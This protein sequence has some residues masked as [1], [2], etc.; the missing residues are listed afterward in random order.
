MLVVMLVLS[1]LDQTIVATALP[2]IVRELGRED[3]AS[4]VFSSYLLSATV[5]VP[6]YGRLADIYGSKPI[7][8]TAITL[9]LA[10]S[11][12]SGVSSSMLGLIWAR[13]LQGAGGGGLLT[14]AMT[15]VAVL[16]EPSARSRLQGMLGAAYGLSVMVGPLLGGSLVEH[17]SW[18][19]AF[20]L[21][22]PI[23][24]VALPVLI[25]KFPHHKPTDGGAMDY[26]GAVLL[27]GA[28]VSLLLSTRTSIT[29]AGMSPLQFAGLAAVL[30]A[31][32][33]VVQLR[34][35]SPLFPLRLFAQ[36]GF[37]AVTILSV[38]TG[39]T[40]FAVV[41]FMP[42]YFQSARGVT[43][44]SSGL[45]TL[46]LMA[47]VTFASIAAGRL[48]A[49][50][51]HVR[52]T[53]LLAGAVTVLG[54]TVLGWL[55][56]DPAVPLGWVSACLVPVGA[57]IGALFPLV[58]V[59]SQTSATP[60]LI[61]IATASAGMF[62]AVSGAVSVSLMGALLERGMAVAMAL[63]IAGAGTGAAA[64]ARALVFGPALSPVLWVCAGVSLV[65]LCAA[66]WLPGR[67][68]AANH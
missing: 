62:R 42:Q 57:G 28:L 14:L 55:V 24:V 6:L 16:F 4:W 12:L 47:A 67:L 64:P 45:Y 3:Y 49:K 61:G 36:R 8:V 30:L 59:I 46:P 60:A 32:F 23:G 18:H 7:V 44:S 27:S 33:V 65:V 9:F 13:A 34:V 38:A 26:A 5:A 43:P 11:L 54:F 25:K 66:A 63:P 21:N 22:L 2:S 58:T 15:S 40:F 19:W 31:M 29:N 52:S 1:A 41:V 17:A 20:L 35:S 68:K 39:L 10:G 53:A 50:T 37:S 48:L 51:G 56:R